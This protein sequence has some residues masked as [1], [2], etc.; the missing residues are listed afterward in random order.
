MLG[1]R[2]FLMAPAKKLS[3][4][5]RMARVFPC[6]IYPF[7]CAGLETVDDLLPCPTCTPGIPKPGSVTSGC[8]ECRSLTIA[9]PECIGRFTRSERVTA[10][11][12]TREMRECQSPS[13]SEGIP[14][15]LLRPPRHCPMDLTKCS[16]RV[17]CAKNRSN[18]LSAKPA[19]W[20]F[21][22]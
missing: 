5:L 1:Q 4:D 22:L 13:V 9:R 10:N 16:L 12:T 6:A 20:R 19:T 14:L 17:S 21:L 8:I 7:S 15:I 11:G 18:S 2:G 3:G